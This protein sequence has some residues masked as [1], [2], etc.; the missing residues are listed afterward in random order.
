MRRIA[1]LWLG[2]SA[3]MLNTLAM[4]QITTATVY[5][6][7]TNSAGLPLSGAQLAIANTATGATRSAT[8]DAAGRF[9]VAQLPPGP[10]ELTV[11][12]S[13]FATLVRGGLQLQVGQEVSL[14]LSMQVGAGTAKVTELGEAPLVSTSTVSVSGV[15]DQQRIEELPLNGRDLSQLPLVQPGVTEVRTG[16]TGISEGMGARI[17]MGGS[18]ADQTGWLLD[19]A[20]IHSPSFLG[21]PGGIAG[22]MLGVDAVQEFQ[23]L[24]SNYM[25][26]VGGISGGVVNLVS[27]AGTNDF[28]GAAYYF[29]RNSDL[30][31]RNFF[32][33]EKQPFKRNQFG[34]SFGGPI[35]K[36]KTFLFGNYEGLIQ[37]LAVTEVASVPDANAD[38]GLIPA[39]G[40]RLLPVTVAPEIR[41]YLALWPLP[42]GPSL[43]RGLAQLVMPG[44]SPA[45]ENY[46]LIRVDHQLR[47][48]QSLFARFSF[49][50]GDNTTPDPLPVTSTKALIH[51]RY[52]TV[53]HEFVAT[54]QLLVSTRLA[55]NRTLLGSNEVPLVS[56]PAALNLFLPGYLPTLSFAGATPFGPNSQNILAEA[57]NLYEFDENVQYA[58]SSHSMKF[59]VQVE[60]VGSNDRGGSVGLNGALTWSILPAFLA[61]QR[62][63]AFTAAVPG[64]SNARSYVQYVY[65]FYFQESW[66]MRRNFTWNLG[67]RYEPFTN[68]TEKHGRIST[69]NDWV[70]ATAF[71]TN[72][73]LFHNASNRDFAPRMGFAWDP[74]GDGKTVVRSGFGLFFVDLLSPYYFVQGQRNPPYFGIA[75]IVLGNLA[76]AVSDLARVAPSLLSPT[77]TP[78]SYME[79]TQWNLNPSYEMKFHL[80]VE[81]QLNKDLSLTVSYLGG[82]GI[83]LWRLAEINDSPAIQANGRDLVIFGT[84][85]VNPNAGFGITRYSDAQSFYN[86]LLIQAQQRL[87]QGIEF[88]ASYTWSKNIDDS[89]TGAGIADYNE[90]TTSQPYNPKVDRSL[91]AL[92]HGQNLV[93]SGVYR[94]PSPIKSGFLSNVINGWQL[95]NIFTASSGTPFTVKVAGFNAPDLGQIPGIQHPDLV[96]GRNNGNIVSGIAAH[97]PSGHAGQKLG[98]PNLYFDPCAFDLPPAPA[99][100]PRASS[101]YGN[102][103]RNILIGPG[104]V[105]F[106]IGLHKS[107]PLGIA[108][109]SRLEFKADLFN[110]FN[111]ANFGLPAATV[112]NAI[113][114]EYVPGAGQITSTVTGARQLQFGLRL[115]F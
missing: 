28:H 26:E 31:A 4:S 42:N 54:P 111:R 51:S 59:G 39:P 47:D 15:V 68:P 12:A 78:N 106:D 93:I 72:I 110:L 8:T 43:G 77:L 11:I 34:A 115:I 74:W 17:S 104:L 73:G 33:R 48:R 66:R 67:L 98:T 91:S 20:N 112:L 60:H 108:K 56:Y 41:P 80:T 38:Q 76:T 82:R 62:F 25:A 55:V 53:Q 24:T 75:T 52:A 50:Q 107:I 102:A 81:R 89:T 65:G 27:R 103:G 6:L 100:F 49:D 85:R 45:S 35:Q 71:Q 61:D 3:L 63:Q 21:T 7:V 46:F 29:L 94:I 69:I 97:C 90:S 58:R 99:G 1:L 2:I 101:F 13:G 18:R 44:N 36:D 105:D 57:Q 14:T 70:T 5:G 79:I 40:G 86:G 114:H 10:Y 37:R 84:P 64:A 9:V 95:A 109:E 32:D 87:R 19:G 92:D 96:P 88:Q 113:N 83:H 22:V 30:D 16:G 23:V